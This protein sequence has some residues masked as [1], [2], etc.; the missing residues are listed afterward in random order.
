[1]YLVLSTLPHF[2]TILPLIKHYNKYTYNYINIII[3]STILSIFYH[4]YKEANHTINF[5]DY[6]CA[7]IWFLY[8][9]HMGYTYTNKVILSKI[10]AGNAIVLY[11]NLQ[12]PKDL[13]YQINHSLWHFIS[14]YKCFY[15]SNLINIGISNLK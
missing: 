2:C 4:I 10:V 7:G 15:L 11:I 14:A 1:M 13:Y 9:V 12:I 5:I 6:L 8:D 3:L